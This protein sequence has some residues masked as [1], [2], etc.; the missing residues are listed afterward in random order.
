MFITLA[1]LGISIV[2]F[3][4]GR[5]RADIV[6][7]SAL[8]ILILVGI[9]TPAEA[10]TSFSDPLVIMT[11]GLFVVSGAILRTGLAKTVGRTILK[12][13]GDDEERLFFLIIAVTTLIGAFVSNTGTVALMMP[14]V[15]SMTM[16]SDINARRL[17]MPLA[18]AGSMG[19]M[20]T[21]IGTAPNLVIQGVLTQNGYTDLKFFSFAPVGAVVFISGALG[22]W[23][24]TK[25]LLSQK[26]NMKEKNLSKP[27][28]ELAKEY[29][30]RTFTAAITEGSS[31]C[32]RTLK[33]LRIPEKYSINITGVIRKSAHPRRFI[34]KG[35]ERSEIAGPATIL[36]AEDVISVIGSEENVKRFI[37]DHS[38][39]LIHGAREEPSSM[40]IA[41]A[42]LL[43]NSGLVDVKVKDSG[44][45]KKY[46]VNILAI[47]HRRQYRSDNLAH[48]VMRAGDTLLVQGRWKDLARLHQDYENIVLVGQPLEEAAKVT[49]NH[50]APLAAMIMLLMIASMAM[51]ILPPVVAIISAAL[52]MI[53]TG[54][55]R[56]MEEAY[57]L[58]NWESV[59][60]LAAMLPMA[61][62]LEKTGTVSLITGGLVDAFSGMGVYGLLAG[63]Y[64]CTSMLTLFISNTATAVLF[65]PIAFKV[66]QSVG[67]SPYPF[68][69][70]V[71]V[72][73]S[74]C[75]AS[76]FSTPSNVMVMTPGRYS[77]VDYVRVGG[78][79]QILMGVIMIIVLPLIFPF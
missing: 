7:L 44:F 43:P 71:T 41:E 5:V 66:A 38:L 13:A 31:V 40:G 27:L 17:L 76:P 8:L 29:R 45:R 37:E 19:G 28:K 18:F 67:A 68:L 75:F 60:L 11:V 36:H 30:I 9:L 69:M 64:L 2:L 78:P 70:A 16:Q 51:N 73:A 54:C 50:K 20:F 26:V 24:L 77:F 55:I 47:N 22:F 3:V 65:A 52:M 63:V 48:E 79:M 61:T 6:A 56:N 4:T 72:A 62:A 57:Q 12:V 33:E 14:I 1:V 53:I 34:L 46:N 35:E 21:L 25:I 23:A 10:L 59:V 15:V 58:I 49:L 39:T 32:D 74:M 42:V